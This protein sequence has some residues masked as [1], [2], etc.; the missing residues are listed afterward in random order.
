MEQPHLSTYCEPSHGDLDTVVLDF[1]DRYYHDFHLRDELL[2]SSR[3]RILH[4]YVP[5]GEEQWF[6]N[7]LHY[8]ST[9]LVYY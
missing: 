9:I 5:N 7:E 6:Y 3:I 2:Q 4:I 1:L 8:C